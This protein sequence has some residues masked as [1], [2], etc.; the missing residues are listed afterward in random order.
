MADQGSDR[1]NSKALAWGGT[2][3]I[4]A[5][6]GALIRNAGAPGFQSGLLGFASKAARQAFAAAPLPVKVASGVVIGA[7]LAANTP[8]GGFGNALGALRAKAGKFF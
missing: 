6:Q 3:A 1:R 4:L 2:T 7:G 8:T 5:A